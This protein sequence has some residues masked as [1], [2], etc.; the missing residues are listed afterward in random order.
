VTTVKRTTPKTP[1]RA[2][3]ARKKPETRP[4]KAA[5][6]PL[7]RT[8]PRPTA[9]AAAVRKPVALPAVAALHE[10][11]V[12]GPVKSRRLGRSLGI[13]LLPPHL[14]LCTFN[15]TYCQ[16]GWTHQPKRGSMAAEAWP[17]PLTVSKAL[18][19]ALKHLE[20]QGER[21]DRV[22][23]AGHGEPT[24]HPQFAEVVAGLRRVRDEL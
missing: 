10:G 20:A 13:N 23:L 9:V 3:S 1:V 2:A 4:T 21:L 12:Y 6:P 16:Y 18:V 14:K 19:A 22:T 7:L 17:S 8:S 5:P 24:L 11:I 15:C